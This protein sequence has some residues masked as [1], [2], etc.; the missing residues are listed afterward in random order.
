[1]WAYGW[2]VDIPAELLPL[3]S[4]FELPSGAQLRRMTSD[5]LDGWVVDLRF[6]HFLYS[7]GAVD[8]TPRSRAFEQ[9][10]FE[11]GEDD[12]HTDEDWKAFAD[13]RAAF[14]AQLVLELDEALALAKRYGVA[15]RHAR[16][17]ETAT[18]R[19]DG[20]EVTVRDA[21]TK[22]DEGHFVL[23]VLADGSDLVVPLRSLILAD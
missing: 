12:L 4:T 10:G 22:H 13:M 3:V 5:G 16:D 19:T 9:L 21:G 8:G 11:G 18:L 20:T 6:S 15:N 17:G 2:V 23:V 7:D 1:M 14:S